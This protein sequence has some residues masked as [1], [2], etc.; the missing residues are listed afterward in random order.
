M[1][2]SAQT[3]MRL[4]PI[5]DMQPRTIQNGM[6][7]GLSPAGYDIRLDQEMLLDPHEF[8]LASA[9]EYFQMPDNLMAIVHDKSSLARRGLSLFN[10]VIEPGWKGYLT[11][12][13]K[14]QSNKE[15]WLPR[16]SPIAQVVFHLLDQPTAMPYAGRYQDQAR[17]PQLAIFAD[18]QTQ[19]ELWEAAA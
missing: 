13:L 5:R 15:L 12:E 14:N 6:T 8:K 16:N 18:D 11:L 7:Y 17:G 3:L 2:A 19:L 9:A 10:T 1:I 4:A